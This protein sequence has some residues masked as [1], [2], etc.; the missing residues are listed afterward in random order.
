MTELKAGVF[1]P[2]FFRFL[3]TTCH[4]QSLCQSKITEMTG[5]RQIEQELIK[6]RKS[7]INHSLYENLRSIE[8]I[9][10]FMEHHIFAVWDFMSLLKALQIKLTCTQVPWMPKVN[11]DA[12]YFIN[13]IVVAEESDIDETGKRVSHYE[14]YL[15]AMEEVGADTR[16]IKKF[17]ELIRAGTPVREA[18]KKAGAPEASR[19]FT[20]FTFDIIETDKPHIIAAVFTFGREDL[21]PDMFQSLVDKLHQK[22]PE[23]LGVLKYYLDR[24]IEIDGDEH[25][26]LSLQMTESLCE[27]YNTRI[28]EATQASK[29]CL[30]RRQQLWSGVENQLK[31][32]V[33]NK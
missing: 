11:T 25:G 2:A 21:I 31:G 3:K 15:N 33:K 18:L 29:K 32:L 9:K 8:D 22:F 23:R 24:H 13:E 5:V 6:E 10:I 28:K 12:A 26:A 16:P 4:N 17:E 20:S 7:S 30:Q 14:M 27:N 19:D 1:T